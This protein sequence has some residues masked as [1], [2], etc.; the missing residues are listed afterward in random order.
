[1]T[2]ASAAS[3]AHL[4]DNVVLRDIGD[5]DLEF[6]RM[7]YRTTRYDIQ[8]SDL[9]DEQKLTLMDQQFLA[10][11]QYYQTQFPEGEFKLIARE[12]IGVGRI[13]VIQSPAELRLIDISL[14][15]EWRGKGLGGALIDDLKNRATQ[16]EIPLRLRV[17]PDNP[18]LKLYRRL[19]FK[20]IADEQINFHM[21]WT[22]ESVRKNDAC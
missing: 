14:V 15:P 3:N 13:Y 16:A 4:P 20:M 9:P 21:E 6:L 8:R 1:M 5:G 10:Q 12:G 19:G 18:A 22:S 11:H 2:G 17:E 7:L